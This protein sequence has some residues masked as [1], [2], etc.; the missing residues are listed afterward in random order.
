MIAPVHIEQR[1]L[2]FAIANGHHLTEND[3]V[4]RGLL[5]LKDAAIES[6][7]RI[8]QNRRSSHQRLERTGGEAFVDR[9]LRLSREGVRQRLMV[10]AERIQGEN[11]AVEED[12]VLRIAVVEAD[13]NRGRT[14]RNRAGSRNRNAAP[15]VA[16]RRRHQLHMAR[17][18]THGISIKRRIHTLPI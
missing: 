3:V 6:S 11:A 13:Q 14:V 17:I 15:L 9:Q 16:E 5:D 8:A 10:S 1:R 18:A 12:I 7:Q 2:R 4:G